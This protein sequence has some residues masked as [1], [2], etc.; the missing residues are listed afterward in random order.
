M[1]QVYANFERNLRDIVDAAR[2]SGARVVLST[3]GVNLKDS[4]PFAS[5]HRADLA[6]DKL[7]AWDAKLRE[8]AAHAEAGRNA[9][10][11]QS[12]LAA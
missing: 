1:A 5:L 4:P 12:Y 6:A 10:A 8:G 3:V 11:L 9:E 2:G 7:T